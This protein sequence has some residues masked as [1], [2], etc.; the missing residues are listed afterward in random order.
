VTED[1]F[2]LASNIARDWL[3][4]QWAKA[5]LVTVINDDPDGVQ[6]L[7]GDFDKVLGLLENLKVDVH[8]Q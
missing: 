8:V 7:D 2:G 1:Y 5:D 3:L 4:D 6:L